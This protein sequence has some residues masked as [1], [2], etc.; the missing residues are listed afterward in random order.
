MVKG[1]ALRLKFNERQLTICYHV[2][3]EKVAINLSQQDD[4]MM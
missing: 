3:S 4:E 1:T 2:A